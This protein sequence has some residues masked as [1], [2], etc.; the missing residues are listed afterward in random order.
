MKEEKEMKLLAVILI[1]SGAL[2]WFLIDT[3]K[4]IIKDVLK[5]VGIFLF[6]LGV[7]RFH[8]CNKKLTKKK[9]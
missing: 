5:G 7:S 8:K 2:V 3:E 4:E 9:K 1:V 6:I